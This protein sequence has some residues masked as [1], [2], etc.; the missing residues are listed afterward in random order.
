[1]I[2]PFR[3]RRISVPGP[4]VQNCACQKP[5]EF[6]KMTSSM[7]RRIR[8]ASKQEL[9]VRIHQYFAEINWVRIP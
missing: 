5:K 9:I 8:V 2:S 3:I 4:L 7:L 1:M 6:S